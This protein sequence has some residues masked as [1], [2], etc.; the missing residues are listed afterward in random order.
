MN[1]VKSGDGKQ[2]WTKAMQEFERK[3][4][5]ENPEKFKEHQAKIAQAGADGRA[6]AIKEKEHYAR[7]KRID[8]KIA[9]WVKR[10]QREW[11]K[12]GL[13]IG[14]A[15]PL[16]PRMDEKDMFQTIEDIFRAHSGLDYLMRDLR[17]DDDKRI[18]IQ[19]WVIPRA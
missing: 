17:M 13:A 8:P 4:R 7:L 2:Q 9:A 15:F 5:A 3:L 12:L 16:S 11:D 19:K 18:H 6:A 10:W 1:K 14:H